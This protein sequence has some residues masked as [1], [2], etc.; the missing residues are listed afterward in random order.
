MRPLSKALSLKQR[1]TATPSVPKN[2]AAPPGLPVEDSPGP[3]ETNLEILGVQGVRATGLYGDL[4]HDVTFWPSV[5]MIMT[6]T[7]GNVSEW[8]L[9]RCGG[10][11]GRGDKLSRA[12]TGALLTL[13]AVGHVF[14]GSFLF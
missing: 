5:L 4:T 11:E 14:L 8:L 12:K 2:L 3:Q 7:P 1:T 10:G 13:S 9:K 6:H